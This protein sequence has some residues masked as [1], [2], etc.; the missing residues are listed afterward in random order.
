MA[1]YSGTPLAKKLGLKPGMKALFQNIPKT[2]LSELNPSLDDV[3]VTK[4]LQDDLDFIHAFTTSKASLKKDFSAWKKHLSKTGCIWVSW[5][6]K[7][8]NLE[9]DLS[10]D[11]VREIGLKAALVDIKVCAVDDQW[12]GLKFVY[13]KEDR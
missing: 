9:T 11:I 6:K 2:V 5:P 10:G 7:A 12:S 1:G 13:R 3:E 4:S 8:S